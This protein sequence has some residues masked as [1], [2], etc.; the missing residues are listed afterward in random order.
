MEQHRWNSHVPLCAAAATAYGYL[1]TARDFYDLEHF[2][3]CLN[4]MACALA[5]LAPIFAADAATGDQ[6]RVDELKVAEGRFQRGATVLVLGDG[7]RLTGLSIRRRDAREAF[8]ILKSIGL[9]GLGIKAA[10]RKLPAPE[11]YLKEGS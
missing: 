9:D 1:V 5:H 8:L 3:A 7:S 2:N 11:E 10:A 4:L 6:Y